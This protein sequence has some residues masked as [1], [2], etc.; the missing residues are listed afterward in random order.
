MRA[1]VIGTGPAGITAAETLRSLDPSGSVVALSSEPFPPYSPPAMADHFLTGREQTLFWKGE[2]ISDRLGI[3]ERRDVVVEAVDTDNKEVVLLGG[4]R[5]GYEGLVIASGSRLYAPID[6]SDYPGVLNFKSL[7]TAEALVE[8]VHSGEAKS[9]LIVGSGF[10][11]TE[12]AILLTDLGVDVK[13]VERL[14]WIMPRVLDS[15]TAEIAEKALVERGVRLQFDALVTQFLGDPRQ[16]T[17]RFENGEEESADLVVAATGVKPHVEFLDGSGVVVNWGI[18]VDDRML[19]SIP[20][21]V[22]A[23]DVAEAADWLT[24]ERYVHAIFPNAVIQGRLAAMNLLGIE[25]RYEGAEAMNSLKHLGVP[26][27]AMGTMSNPDEIV[28]F[29][30][31]NALRTVYLRDGRIIGVQLAGD[32]SSA[33]LY[34]S[35]ML[36]RTNVESFRKQLADPRFDVAKLVFATSS[37]MV[38]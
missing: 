28:S 6:G 36:R 9:A 26:I 1:V 25:S 24:G 27:V 8:R 31:D 10:I 2:D 38:A 35:L 4:E 18:Q 20:F 15:Q 13:M 12:L 37:D 16:P 30:S 17:V 14:S 34:R 7:R 11:G 32:I 19:T 21:V 5:I 29:R 22:A 23:G 33:G 3:E